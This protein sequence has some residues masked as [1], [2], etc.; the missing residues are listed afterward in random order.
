M[1]PRKKKQ[2]ELTPIDKKILNAM[3]DLKDTNLNLI[4]RN[5]GLSKSTVHNRIK[6]LKNSGFLKGTMPVISQDFIQRQI[7]AVSLI[8]AKYGPEYAEEV[9]KRIANI[10]GIWA[11]YFVLGSNDFV[12]LIRAKSKDELEYIVNELTKTEGV[13]R[14]DTIMVIKILKEDLAESLKLTY[15]DFQ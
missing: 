8:K 1:S 5:V 9:G 4:S 13:E 14:S 12:A 10:R 3:I 7:T 15:S 6:K 11:V 2:I